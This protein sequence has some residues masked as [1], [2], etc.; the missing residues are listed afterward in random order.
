MVLVKHNKLQ[1]TPLPFSKFFLSVFIDYQ[2]KQQVIYTIEYT[3][4][5]LG[6]QS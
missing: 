2:D 5:I 1:H 4:N 6:I 3:R